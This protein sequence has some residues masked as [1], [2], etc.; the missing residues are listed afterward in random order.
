MLVSGVLTG[1]A[2]LDAVSFAPYAMHWGTA[3]CEIE[4]EG[5]GTSRAGDKYTYSGGV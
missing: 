1:A 5:V 3:E 4:P 2:L